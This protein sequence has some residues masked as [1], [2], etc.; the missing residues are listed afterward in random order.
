MSWNETV[1]VLPASVVIALFCVFRVC[2]PPAPSSSRPAA[3]ITPDCVTVPVEDSVTLPVAFV[4]ATSKPVLSCRD[5]DVIEV[6][7][8]SNVVIAL[9]CVPRL[10]VPPAP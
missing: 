5:T 1:P 2:V 3:V 4:P 10:N 9:F 8:A 7:S 6:L